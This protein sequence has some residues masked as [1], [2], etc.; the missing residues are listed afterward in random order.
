MQSGIDGP[1]IERLR[2]SLRL[3]T[4][5]LAVYDTEPD[6]GFAP[7]IEVKG[8]ACC[9][10]YYDRWIAG[11]T[12]VIRKGSFGCPGAQRALGLQ[13][14]Y[15]DTMAH[16]L[17]DGVGAPPG[18]G[19]RASAEIAQAFLDRAVP[20]AVRGET[21]LL[22]PL[23]PE[24][25][26]AVRTV[27][28][29]VDPDRLGALMT[30]AGYWSPDTRLV[31]AP[32]SSGCGHLWR[33]VFYDGEDHPVIG[34]TDIAM[35]KYLPPEI[36]TFTVSPARFRQMLGAPDDC[37]LYKDWWGGLMDHRKSAAGK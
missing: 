30:L 14:S 29:L 2:K 17:T 4:P 10:A 25:W 9:F 28:F 11:E 3:T 6:D 12:A 36:L 1:S 37:F 13:K 24:K 33:E 15:P 26:D 23:R 32:F 21:V 5:I 34:A 16:F 19:L 7:C 27:T 22:G 18:E 8:H 20:P 31:S 35:R